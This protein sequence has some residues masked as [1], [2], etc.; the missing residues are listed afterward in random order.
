MRVKTMIFPIVLFLLVLSP[1]FIP[2]TVTVF[3][4]VD[5]GRQRRGVRPISSRREFRPAIGRV[6]AAA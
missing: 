6:P 4:V 2:V 1:L 5:N 3:H